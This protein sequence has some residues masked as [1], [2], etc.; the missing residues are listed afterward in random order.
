MNCSGT[1]LPHCSTD[2][3]SRRRRGGLF[4][5]ST[6]TGF[7]VVIVLRR[8]ERNSPRP[9]GRVSRNHPANHPARIADGLHIGIPPGIE[10]SGRAGGEARPKPGPPRSPP[11]DPLPSCR[12]SRPGRR[13][14]WSRRM[15]NSLGHWVLS[16][17]IRGTRK[18]II[19]A[20]WLGGW[21]AG[22]LGGWVA[23]VAGWL[24][25]T[26]SDFGSEGALRSALSTITLIASGLN[27]GR[28]TGPD[29]GRR[30]IQMPVLHPYWAF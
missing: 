7:G 1:C 30:R 26:L 6:L 3:A 12:S 23:G 16:S 24:G 25:V 14:W 17:S 28:R 4:C 8:A 9:G 20:G 19:L 5:P 21:V 27:L 22:W 2:G 29:R 18:L 10:P 15:I 11:D 13:M